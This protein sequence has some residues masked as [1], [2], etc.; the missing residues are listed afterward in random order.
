[1]DSENNTTIAGN[2]TLND[3]AQGCHNLTVYA[4]DET[5]NTGTAETI[6]FTISR[7][8][9]TSPVWLDSILLLISTVTITAIAIIAVVY[10]WKR[11]H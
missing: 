7:E 9:G 11:K 4:T 2:T 10:I 3:M 5:G 6:Y 1:L 8:E